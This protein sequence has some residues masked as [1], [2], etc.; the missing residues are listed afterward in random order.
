MSASNQMTPQQTQ[1]LTE[2]KFYLLRQMPYF[3]IFLIGVPLIE[4]WSIP[5]ACTNYREIRFNP[6]FMLGGSGKRPALRPRSEVVFVKAHEVLHMAFKHGLR[7]S[8]RDPKLWNVACDYAIN[9]ILHDSQVGTYP[10]PDIDPQTGKPYPKLLDENFRGWSAE[11]IYD[12]LEKKR[13]QQGGGS[14]INHNGVVIDLRSNDP[15]GLGGFE[16]PVN[17]DGSG[18]TPAQKAELERDIDSKNSQASASAKSQGKLPAGLEV[19][20]KQALKP[21]VDWRERLRQFVGRNIP[22]DMT[23]ARPRKRFLWNDLYL[24]SVDKRGVGKI[25]AIMDTSGS[26][27]FS[28][29]KSEGAQFYGETKSIHED[30][31]P[32]ELH[33]MYCDAEVAG[34]DVFTPSD[35]IYLKPRGGGGTDFRPPFKRVE[36]LQLDIQ[37]AIYLTDMYGT[38]PEKAPPYPVL[39]VATSDIVAPFGETVRI[40]K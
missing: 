26:I 37:C 14:K 17:A 1:L 7:M 28:D 18:L 34:H 6:E 11:A 29:P 4:D 9:I 16:K 38:F 23:W 24:P 15:G 5:T 10:E 20:L 32:E 8:F 12:H 30:V 31:M 19:L 36:E 2:A 35:E 22:V 27:N 39:W 3:G 13:Q 33:V 21:E 40:M 25:L